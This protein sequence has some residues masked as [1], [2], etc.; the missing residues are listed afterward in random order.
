MSLVACF[1]FCLTD[2]SGKTYTFRTKICPP[3]TIIG[4]IIDQSRVGVVYPSALVQCEIG[5][6]YGSRSEMIMIMTMTIN[7]NGEVVSV[8]LRAIDDDDR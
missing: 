3:E 5:N 8:M 1:V 2:E 7:V 6:K 4:L